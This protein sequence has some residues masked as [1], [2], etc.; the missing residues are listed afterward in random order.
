MKHII[1]FAFF[2]IFTTC[3]AQ[4]TKLLL[5]QELISDLSDTPIY[6]WLTENVN[7][8]IEWKEEFKY[9]D[10]ID[11]YSITYL[12]DGLKVNGLLVKPRKKENILV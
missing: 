11:I 8:Q 10:S 12:S 9:I 4:E 2:L 1:I 7:G 3:K 6:P 5:R